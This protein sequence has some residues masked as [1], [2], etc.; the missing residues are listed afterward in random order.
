MNIKINKE[1]AQLLF[2]CEEK[3]HVIG[4]NLYRT[5]NENSDKDILVIYKSEFQSDDYYPNYHQFQYDDVENNTDYIFTSQERFW[6]N[7]LSGD[8]TINADIILANPMYKDDEKLN[9]LRTF[10]IIKSFIGFAK[11]DIKQ[12]EMNK[13]K[14]KIFHINRSLHCAEKL[15]NNEVP[16]ILEFQYLNIFDNIF[17]LK[18]KE[19]DLRLLCNRGYE[20]GTLAKYPLKPICSPINE[21][22]KLLIDANNTKNF[23]YE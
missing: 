17:N 4:S 7:L 13:G 23:T 18:Q 15:L 21:L 1:Q 14:N 16:D 8:S 2:N 12:Y 9:I 22:E 20:L 5:N 6:H 10:N 11:R 19:A 3:R